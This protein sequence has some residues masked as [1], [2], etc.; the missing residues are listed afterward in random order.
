[1]HGYPDDHTVWDGVAEELAHDF[2]VVTYDVRGAG[3]SD[4]PSGRAAYRLSQLVDDLLTVADAVSPEEPVHLVGHDWGS[5]QAWA[6]VTDPRHQGRFRSFTSISGP[7]LGHAAAW[8]RRIRRHPRA[9]AKQLVASSYVG[10][11]QVP[12]LPELLIRRGVLDRVVR[13]SEQVGRS[14]EPAPGRNRADAATGLQL[15]RANL[16]LLTRTPQ[17]RPTGVPVQ[18]IAPRRDPH[19]TPALQLQAPAPYV[20]HLVGRVVDGNH[21]VVKHQPDLIAG[22]V[23]EFVAGLPD[24]PE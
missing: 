6:A 1:M 20:D 10:L 17:P 8:L 11:F 21:W 24:R 12:V 13:R 19:V 5:I 14:G 23:R 2:H 16:G 4:R 15:Y 22:L 3:S 18:V 7:D 9:T